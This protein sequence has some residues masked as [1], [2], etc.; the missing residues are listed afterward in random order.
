MSLPLVSCEK[1]AAQHAEKLRKKPCLN[2]K[3][4]ALPR[5]VAGLKLARTTLY[6]SKLGLS[7]F[8]APLPGISLP[9]LVTE[10]SK[11]NETE[12]QLGDW[13]SAF[14]PAAGRVTPDGLPLY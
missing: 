1:H 7:A 4:A 9:L 3:S 2:Y 11:S 5:V 10:W 6:I 8:S 13:R 12:A 14:F